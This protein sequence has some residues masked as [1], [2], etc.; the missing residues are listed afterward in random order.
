MSF[1]PLTAAFDAGKIL[2]EKLWPDP[3]KQSEEMRKLEQLRQGGD[4]AQ[5]NAQVQLMIGQIEI[6]KVEA[7]SSNWFV[8]SWRPF[9]GWICGLALAYSAILEP[10]M[11]F[12]AKISGY[13]GSFPVIDTTLT[14]QVLLG[15]LG[16]V[17]ARTREKE[18]GVHS[19]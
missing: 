8:S 14:M 12:A 15:M 1:D 10:F 13:T 18:K 11:R 19:K 17:A 2:I 16:L 7:A 5:L 3:V 6:N 9:I 4:I